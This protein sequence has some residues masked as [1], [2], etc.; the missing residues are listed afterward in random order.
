MSVATPV[1]TAREV[2]EERDII[3]WARSP[4]DLLRLL[5]LGGC[6]GLLA[7]LTVWAEGAVIG[8]EE[9]LLRLL[10]FVP[11]PA[12]RILA[13]FSQILA[14]LVI[15]IVWLIPLVTRQFRLFGYVLAG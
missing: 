12:E 2:V 5:V 11:S 9:A 15:A 4:S 10:N 7:A 1:A 13:G 8:F 3:R 14:G 6:A